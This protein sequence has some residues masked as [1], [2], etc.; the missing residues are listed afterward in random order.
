MRKS[1]PTMGQMLI[2]QLKSGDWL[3]AERVRIAGS[4]AFIAYI[5]LL[6][7]VVFFPNGFKSAN[8][9]YLILDF[10]SFWTAAKLALAGDSLTPYSG[11]PFL[12]LQ[13]EWTGFQDTSF[14]FFYPPT[15]LVYV[16]PFGHFSQPIAYFLFNL[17]GFGLVILFGRALFKSWKSAFILCAFPAAMNCMLH[18]QNGLLSAALL[19]GAMLC[20]QHRRFVLAGIFIGLLSY[21]PQLGLIIPLALLFAR[22][23]HTFLSAAVTTIAIA[24]VSLLIFGLETWMAFFEQL[25]IASYVLR[26]GI[27]NWEKMVSVYAALRVLGLSDTWASAIQILVSLAIVLLLFQIW[28]PKPHHTQQSQAY[29]DKEM[30]NRSAILIAGGLVFTPFALAYDFMILIVPIAYLVK[31]GVEEGFQPYEKTILAIIVLLSAITSRFALT[32]GIPI[33]PLLPLA[34]VGL[35]AYR[36]WTS[37]SHKTID[38]PQETN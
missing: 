4:F 20:L 30:A 12:E 15:W 22:H 28:R 29:T 6:V 18:G 32:T 37:S 27:V 14:A 10:N 25:P 3:N 24:V 5:G 38:L 33:A 34:I 11:Q 35:G 19:G 17:I 23:W 9:Q 26:N 2:E 13:K 16:L 36:H 7:F 31:S 21:K 8:G 1:K